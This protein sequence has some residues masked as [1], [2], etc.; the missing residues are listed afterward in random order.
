MWSEILAA[1]FGGGVGQALGYVLRKRSQ[2]KENIENWYKNALS[3]I[4]HGRGICESAQKRSNL[5]YGNISTQSH[6]LSQRLKAHVNPYPEE[7]DE[8]AVAQIQNLAR[9]F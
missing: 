6:D 5:N 1:I 7:V 2:E 9:I 8:T 4:S 3:L